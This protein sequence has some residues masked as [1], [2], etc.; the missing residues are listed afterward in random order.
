MDM[1]LKA[2]S[3]K[4]YPDGAVQSGDRGR[5]WIPSRS[6]ARVPAPPRKRLAPAAKMP[7]Q[8]VVLDP[9][10]VYLTQMASGCW[11]FTHSRKLHGGRFRERQAAIRYIRRE[12]G[13][14]TLVI[15]HPPKV[16]QPP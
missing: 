4:S 12:F 8:R 1:W 9:D 16:T 2:L 6:P 13:A 7:K 5:R 14:T 3:A 10:L 11:E 15:L